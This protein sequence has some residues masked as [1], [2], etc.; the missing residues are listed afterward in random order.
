MPNPRQIALLRRRARQH[1]DDAACVDGERQT[2]LCDDLGLDADGPTRTNQSVDRLHSNRLERSQK[3]RAS[4]ASRRSAKA[5]GRTVRVLDFRL[6][7]WALGCVVRVMRAP[8]N[9]SSALPGKTYTS[10]T[11]NPAA[12]AGWQGGAVFI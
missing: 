8:Q 6:V 5:T 12:T 11:L 3:R 9:R 10:S 7:F 1:L 4:I 2:F